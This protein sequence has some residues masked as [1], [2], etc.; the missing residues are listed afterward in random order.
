MPD[1]KPP[2]NQQISAGDRSTNY[3][4][5]GNINVTNTVS[6]AAS[7][8]L[9]HRASNAQIAR[10]DPKTAELLIRAS[11]APASPPLPHLGPP[12]LK[13]LIAIIMALMFAT[14]LVF[15][16]SPARPPSPSISP[17]TVPAIP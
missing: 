10:F 6:Q 12:Y 5:A 4:A 17:P 1:E 2:P 16:L 9:I 15:Y 14:A 3:A 13:I 11:R 8:P 7:E